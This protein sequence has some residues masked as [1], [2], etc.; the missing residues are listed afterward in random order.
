ME[1]KFLILSFEQKVLKVVLSNYDLLLAIIV[2]G[3]LNRQTMFFQTNFITS[4]SLM[5]A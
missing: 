4:L 3:I 2:W 1:Y 5:L